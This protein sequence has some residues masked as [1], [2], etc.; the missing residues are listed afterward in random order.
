MTLNKIPL[1]SIHTPLLQFSVVQNIEDLQKAFAVRAIVF[2]EEQNVTYVEEVDGFDFSSTH[3]LGV[4]ENEPVAAA[5]MQ[6]FKDYVKI[7]RLAVRKAYRG[8]GIGKEMFAFVL[9][10]VTSMG[11]TKISLSA[12]AYLVKFYEDFGFVRK[13]EKFLEANIEHYCMEKYML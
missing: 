12:Q 11:Y 5:R 13:G 3:F 9:N 7:G 4:I 6:L 10:H 1:K 2:V 8:K